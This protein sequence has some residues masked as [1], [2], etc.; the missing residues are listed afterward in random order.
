MTETFREDGRDLR[1][2]GGSAL[3]LDPSTPDPWSALPCGVALVVGDGTVVRANAALRRWL[4]RDVVGERLTDLLTPGARLLWHTT[5]APRL[6][7]DGALTG[8]SL[9]LVAADGGR[10]AVLL[11]A[12]TDDDD[13]DPGRARPIHLALVRADERLAYETRLVDARV[14]AEA[15]ARRTRVLQRATEACS[16]SVTTE[17]LLDGVVTAV[18]TEPTTPAAA[19]WLA[20]DDG[21][22]VLHAADGLGGGSVD[23]LGRA[24]AGSVIDRA[25]RT[26][27]PQA[28][29]VDDAHR[30][31][32]RPAGPEADVDADVDADCIEALRQTGGERL[33]VVPVTD[34]S[35]RHGALGLVLRPG[36]PDAPE[37][38]SVHG[39]LGALLGQAL[40]RTR[41]LARLRHESLHDPLT[42]LANRL[43]VSSTVEAAL[44]RSHRHGTPTT[45]LLVDLD[46][47]KGV[48][49]TFGHAAG[50]VVLVA[51]AD[52]LRTAVRTRDLVG[53]IG[54]DEFVVV[55]EGVDDDGA[56][57]LA[58]RVRHLLAHPVD[59][60]GG[61]VTVTASVG[62]AV[63][64]G[65][66]PAAV[67]TVL[68]QA[69]AAMYDAKR[70][71]K[72]R[73]AIRSTTGGRTAVPAGVQD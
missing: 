66:D 58:E 17:D 72:D 64:S 27:E 22:L 23:A 16:G 61:T 5:H 6:A 15:A 48:N 11:A 57:A 65:D 10:V 50:D 37:E 7:R 33:L 31:G 36:V 28:V 47:F 21:H 26:G 44:A 63:H 18:V 42:G 4:G 13:A 38:L 14:E 67:S 52:R 45:L 39:T 12:R 56:A 20:T 55:A 24:P 40:S 68:T 9:E 30:S 71:G 62:V 3:H 8:T 2:Q 34:G 70:A 53:R 60:D 59:V 73:H 49:D 35:V 1:T 43:L 29:R 19:I 25:W 46:G 41:L 32:E 51:T 69:D 54:G